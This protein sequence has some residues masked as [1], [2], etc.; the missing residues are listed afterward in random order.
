MCLWV[1]GCGGEGA[2]EETTHLVAI[3]QVIGDVMS[4]H[5]ID[6][7]IIHQHLIIREHRLTIHILTMHVGDIQG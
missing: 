3:S 2:S 1:F 7:I 4:H 5:M 6:N